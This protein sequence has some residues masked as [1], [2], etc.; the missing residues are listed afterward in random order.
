MMRKFAR[1]DCPNTCSGHGTCTTKGNGY[2]ARATKA[3][4]AAT[5]PGVLV[6]LD[7]RG[8]MSRLL[9]IVLTNWQRARIVELATTPQ[10]CVSAT[11]VSPAL[12]AIE[13]SV[14]MIVVVSCPNDCGKHGEC[15]SMK[16]HAVRKD[17]GLPPAVVYNSI[18]DSEMVHG[19]V[20]E[21]GY[22]GGDCSDRTKSVAVISLIFEKHLEHLVYIFFSGIGLCPSG[23]DPLTGAATDSLFGFQ[24]NEKQTV[25]C[26]ATV[27]VCKIVFSH[28]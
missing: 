24:K 15:R 11:L 25:L 12:R 14:L 10:E 9:R 7:W 27:R 3:S 18:W 19:C 28:L 20:C 4:R 22:G 26:A 23:D 6:R 1:G 5:A 13:S 16:L 21:E 17:K 2:F 8:M